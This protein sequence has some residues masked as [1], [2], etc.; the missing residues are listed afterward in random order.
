MVR[1]TIVSSLPRDGHSAK[2]VHGDAYPVCKKVCRSE[3]LVGESAIDRALEDLRADPTLAEIVQTVPSP[4]LR[5]VVADFARL[6]FVSGV[7]GTG[8]PKLIDRLRGFEE[9]GAFGRGELSEGSCG[10]YVPFEKRYNQGR[11][12]CLD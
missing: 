11:A 9:H 3:R 6:G 12:A 5:N 2:W 10:I 7:E 4:E 1:P 8:L